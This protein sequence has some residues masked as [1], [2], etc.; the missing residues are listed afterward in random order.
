MSTHDPRVN[1]RLLERQL[2]LGGVALLAVLGGLALERATDSDPP[3]PPPVEAPP[4]AGRWYEAAVGTY[5]PGL[6]GRTTDCQVRLT[7]ATRGVAHPVLP[8]GARI[9]V[10]YGGREVDTRVI[11]KGPFGAGQ[12]F[13]LTQAL[14]ADLGLSGVQIV[15]WRFSGAR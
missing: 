7:R 5:G 9:V 13:A 4:V 1:R 14:A 12:E 11:D 15:R 8:C 3:S 10:S 6:F 2:A